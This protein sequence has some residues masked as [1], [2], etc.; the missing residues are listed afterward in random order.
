MDIRSQERI[1]QVAPK[2]GAIVTEL[3]VQAAA[4]GVEIRVTQGLRSWNMQ[5]ALYMQGR[6]TLETVNDARHAVGLYLIA[7]AENHIVTKAQPGHGWHEF[8][9]AVDVVPDDLEKAGFQPDWHDEHPVWQQMIGIGIGLG[10]KSGSTFRTFKD[11]PHFQPSTVPGS[12]TDETRQIFQQ[13]GMQ[14]VW[15]LYQ[16]A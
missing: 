14:A 15:E 9:L 13:A 1:A 6:E 5:G 12:P 4:Q 2:F 7:E 11:N 3:V 10:L 8:G 16:L